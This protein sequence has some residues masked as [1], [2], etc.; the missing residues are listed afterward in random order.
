[1]IPRTCTR[2]T[3]EQQRIGVFEDTLDPRSQSDPYPRI[4][5]LPA[6]ATTERPKRLPNGF[7]ITR[8]STNSNRNV[9]EK[10]LAKEPPHDSMQWDGEKDTYVVQEESAQKARSVPQTPRRYYGTREPQAS[11]RDGRKSSPAKH[12]CARLLMSHCGWPE[13]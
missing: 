11:E 9:T 13:I 1:M 7:I 3:D 6:P 10:P 12:E 8:E 5:G 2:T 4:Q